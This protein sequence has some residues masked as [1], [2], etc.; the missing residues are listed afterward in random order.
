[1]RTY[2]SA[3]KI[4]VLQRSDFVLPESDP[5]PKISFIVL[6]VTKILGYTSV[7]IVRNFLFG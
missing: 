1:M 6:H 2:V 5:D 4:T 7:S 3:S